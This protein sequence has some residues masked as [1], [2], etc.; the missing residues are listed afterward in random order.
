MGNVMQLK[1]QKLPLWHL[2]LRL[3]QALR[4]FERTEAEHRVSENEVNTLREQ[5]A[6]ARKEMDHG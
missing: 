1:R 2:E 3:A 6:E 5:I 4:K